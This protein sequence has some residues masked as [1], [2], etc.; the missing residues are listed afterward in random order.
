MRDLAHDLHSKRQRPRPKG[1]PRLQRDEPSAVVVLGRPVIPGAPITVRDSQQWKICDIPQ[2]I[3]FEPRCPLLPLSP[4]QT[5]V[6]TPSI[7]S[8]RRFFG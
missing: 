3:R 5:Q 6:E 4:V 1:H 8:K 7:G 2:D